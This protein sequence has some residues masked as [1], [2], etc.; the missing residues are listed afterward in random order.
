MA[1]SKRREPFDPSNSF[2][3]Y[4]NIREDTTFN[5]KDNMKFDV[6]YL[7]TSLNLKD[8]K[9]TVDEWAKVIN[10]WGER[11]GWNKNLDLPSQFANFHAEISEGWEEYRNGRGI[12]EVYYNWDICTCELYPEHRQTLEL[13]APGC[14]ATKPEGIPTELAD[15]VIRVLHTCEFYGIDLESIMKLKM[16]Y[17]ETREYRH[18][19]KIA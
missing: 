6:E 5:N 1:I 18:G 17:N 13:H 4:K 11:K 3:D 9:L 15:L 8:A 16:K 19:G 10:D 12:T 7:R 14:P 2:I